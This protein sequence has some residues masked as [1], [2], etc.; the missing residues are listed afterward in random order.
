MPFSMF[1]EICSSI[2]ATHNLQDDK[3]DAK[4]EEPIKLSLLVLGSLSIMASGCTFDAVEELT[5]V[6]QDKHVN[7]FHDYFCTCG[8]DAAKEI[9]CL[10]HDEEIC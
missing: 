5:C 4:G 7:I 8:Q 2:K 1:L 3:R 6:S 9:I 10:P